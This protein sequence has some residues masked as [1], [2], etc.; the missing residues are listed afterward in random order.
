MALLWVKNYL[1]MQIVWWIVLI[2]DNLS[3]VITRTNHNDADKACNASSETDDAMPCE[4]EGEL[5]LPMQTLASFRRADRALKALEGEVLSRH[6]LTATQF[7]VLQSLEAY[8]EMRVCQLVRSMLST[9]GNMTVVLRNM[10]RDGLIA[11][12]PNPDDA[13]SH[14][15][16]LT[17][18]GHELTAQVLP[19]FVERLG[20]VIASALD[21]NEQQEL[22]R[23]ASQLQESCNRG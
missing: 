17:T 11:R 3:L 12:R 18:R 21:E 22:I 20:G 6:G 15:V 4:R 7:S 5:S 10:E 9:S 16:R 2:S 14:F 1:H 23:I 13:R 8:G 19:E